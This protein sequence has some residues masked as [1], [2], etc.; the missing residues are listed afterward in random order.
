MG[1]GV[2]QG[3]GV[4]YTKMLCMLYQFMLLKEEK[5]RR[6]NWVGGGGGRKTWGVYSSVSQ[7]Q[8]L[9]LFCCMVHDN[10]TEFI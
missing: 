10:L 5:K 7:I 9:V 2:F 6:K 4:W 8:N 1:G 3:V